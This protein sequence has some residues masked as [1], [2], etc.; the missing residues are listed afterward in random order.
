MTYYGSIMEI[1]ELNFSSKFHV[2]FYC[3]WYQVEKD[4]YGLICVDFIK[5]C[6]INDPFVML[7]QVQQLFYVSNPVIDGL[8]YVTHSILS[9]LYN[10]D[11]KINTNDGSTYN[12]YELH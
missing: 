6:C 2:V 8:H 11:S 3:Q 9:D 4:D 12:T 7:A 5:L 10:V 1:L